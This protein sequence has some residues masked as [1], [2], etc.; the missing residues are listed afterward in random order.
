MKV[1]QTGAI[2]SKIE[3]FILKKSTWEFLRNPLP[4]KKFI[5]DGATFLASN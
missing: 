4:K 1:A 3:V 5:K 2:L